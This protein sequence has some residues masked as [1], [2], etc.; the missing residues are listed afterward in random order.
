MIKL[1][2]LI[3]K[4]T[5]LNEVEEVD[6][7][8]DVITLSERGYTY[9]K[10]QIDEL[11][12]KA[13][14]W[15]VPPM[16]LHVIKE[17][18]VTKEVMVNAFTG[19]LVP[20][21]VNQDPAAEPRKLQFKQYQVKLVGE[22]PRVEGYEFIAK[23]EH[24]PEGN[25]LNF[26]PHASV[27]NLPP[28]YHT[29]GQ[30][31]DV[32]LTA[33]DRFNTFILKLEKEDPQRFPNKKAGDLI[34]VGSSCLKR[35]LPGVSSDALIG[36]AEMIDLIRQ[37]AEAAGEMD[38]FEG[39]GGG[40]RGNYIGRDSL[41]FNIMAVYLHIGKYVSKKKAEEFQSTSTLEDAYDV[42]FPRPNDKNDVRERLRTDEAFKKKVEDLLQEF[43]QWLTTKDFDKAAA[44]NPNYASFY[45]NAKVLSKLETIGFN[46]ANKLSAMFGMFLYDKGQI[47]KSAARAKESEGF[48][49]LG[50]IGEKI[51][52]KVKVKKI[53]EYESQY[54]RG[55]IVSMVGELTETDPATNQ[56]VIKKGNVIY[57]T[58][59]FE[60]DE[61][62]EAELQATVKA[63][64]I[65][66]Y[67]NLPETQ[68]TRAKIT[69]FI[70][71]PEKNVGKEKLKEWS[72]KIRIHNVT[73]NGRWNKEGNG[74]I[75]QLHFY[76]SSEENP[77]MESAATGGVYGSVDLSPEEF[78]KYEPFAGHIVEA[79]VKLAR[80]VDKNKFAE[81]NFKVAKVDVT[82]DLGPIPARQN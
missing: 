59:N 60:L 53:K 69:N 58:N 76:I 29:A 71:H 73:S 35:F 16:E 28:E 30:K 3:N 27:K 9:L 48:T 61:S 54:G 39:G 42:M 32:C 31:C 41:M 64:Q 57:F 70:T 81:G 5:I 65:S 75:P 79:N 46:N 13:M 74:W 25:L 66:K 68:I 15:H 45:Q 56:N 11:N 72:G 18:I 10:T 21:G 49:Y 26:N 7:S 38:D 51:K 34:M 19:Q 55:L 23:V 62:E 47:E 8:K 37:H 78:T 2:N 36:Y 1:C 43:N 4:R 52:M 24:T 22:P 50:K 12:K 17:E 20:G 14:R 77:E 80:A 63:Q 67:T 82:K 6:L 40:G 44:E 33:R